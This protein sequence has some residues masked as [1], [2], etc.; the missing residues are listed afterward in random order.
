MAPSYRICG[1]LFGLILLLMMAC[2][3]NLPESVQLAY[4]ELPEELD[5]NI[6]VKPVLSDKCFACHGP[7]KGKIKAG[8][9]LHTAE[10]AYAELP[11]SPGQKAIVP[12]S[13]KNSEAFHRI[14]STDPETIMPPPEF[15]IQLSDYEK[16]VLIKW[17][18][19]GA[20][21]EPH[22][23]FIKPE[24]P[25]VPEVDNTARVY[26]PI[27]HFVLKKLAQQQ[28]NPSPPAEKELLLRRLT[29]DLTGLPPTIE[30]INTFLA[31]DSENA[32]EKQVD[33]LL[34]SVHY[35]EKM[36]TDWM[37]V[38]RFSDTYGYQVDR[39]RDMSPWRDWVIESFNN[40]QPYDEFLTWQLAGDLLPNPTKE[41]ILATGFNRLH[42]LNMED[43]VIGEEYRVE[44]VSDRVAVLGDGILGLTLSCAKCHDHKYDPISQKEYYEMYGFFN[45]INETGQISWDKAVPPP[46]LELPTE[47]QEKILK[48]LTASIKSKEENLEKIT[49]S[50]RA[51]IAQWIDQG[52]YKPLVAKTPEKGLVAHYPLE[53]KLTNVLNRRQKPRMDRFAS[54]KEVPV[55]AEGHSGNGL[56]LDGDAWMECKEVGIFKRSDAFSIGLWVKMPAA[57]EEGVIFHKNKGTTLH[58]YRGYHLYLKDKKLEWV[59]ARTMPENAIVLTTLDELP[60]EKWVHLMVTYDGSSCAA[61]TSIFVNG[62]QAKTTTVKDNL[63]RDIVFN[64]L[65]DIIYPEP[66]EPSLKI[67]GRWRGVGIKGA[68]VDDILVYE[69]ALIDSEVSQIA[70]NPTTKLLAETLPTDLSTEQQST[71]AQY[72]LTHYSTP[73]QKEKEQL[74]KVR[75]ALVDSMETVQE[76]MVMQEMETPRKTFILGRGVYDNYEEEVTPNTVQSV[77]PMPDDLP[78]NRL[79]LAQW[80]V[81]QDNP[82]TARV[83]VNRYWQ[84]YFGR[85]LVKTAQDFGNQGELPT[86]PE[87]LDWLAVTFVESGWNVKALQKLMVMSATYRQSSF[88]SKGLLAVD[89]ANKWLARGPNLRLT[90]EM[91]RDNALAA[92]G[93]LNR[94]VGGESVYPYQPEGLWAMNF[95]PYPQDTGEKLYRRS[96]Y[97]M[98]RRTIP[99][100]TLATFDQPDR[101]LCTVNRQKT[102]TPLQALVLLNDPTF[103][104]A[105]KVIGENMTR[106][107][108]DTAS[109]TQTYVRLTGK[110]PSGTELNLLLKMREEEYHILKVNP[111]KSK[112]WLAAGAYQID[113]NLDKNR[114]VANAI[115][116][117]LILNGDVAI[118]KR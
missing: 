33:R 4:Q 108:N 1:V 89:K 111:E 16:A 104:E 66:L 45:T 73:Y 25:A 105:A 117:S 69:R 22:W 58:S 77:L 61:G 55:F 93:L 62:V 36:A 103:V 83:A 81:H 18:E 26:N 102:N 79:G 13:L 60:K 65:E 12:H 88:T 113:P 3:P 75:Q 23:A 29:L 86:H 42:P 19:D 76:V 71:L 47:R 38:A 37:D 32:Y 35:G 2:Q 110:K 44:S 92:S 63:T 27:D 116:A 17:M 95:D 8:L 53:N 90:S 43:G 9:Q 28:L 59:M 72:Y 87:L 82:L 6:H 14:V 106:I 107:E 94:Q 10:L 96:L 85:G 15:N 24:K 20:E 39:Y 30:E 97:T 99:N 100:P 48:E 5:F 112:G 98:W 114:V 78:K 56:L 80:I 57:T 118:M 91:L 50:E 68:V 31:D 40:N 101:N 74:A 49:E 11:E 46:V 51:A 109:I 21:Y 41:Q 67:G 64:Y 34:A 84:H 52:K 7:D 115:V 70:Q 54:P